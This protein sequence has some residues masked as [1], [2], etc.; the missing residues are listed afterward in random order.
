[1]KNFFKKLFNI[2][3]ISV[4]GDINLGFWSTIAKPIIVLAPMA[5]VTDCAFREVIA[6]Y[7]KPD[8]MWTEFVSADGL[9]CGGFEHLK[10]DLIFS[11]A[12]KPIVAQFFTSN[13]DHME[14][15]ARL[16]SEMGFDG[17]D[18]NMG[19]PD[20]SI[21]RQGCGSA[22]IK[23]PAKAREIIRAAIKGSGGLPVSV[24]T[25][26][27]YN[28]DQL[29]EWL[30]ELLA[31]NPAVVTIHARTRKEM[32][33]VPARWERIKRAVEIRNE[34]KAKTLIFG[35]G[36]ILSPE[37]AF[38]IAK[39]TG[40]DG[41]M[42]GKGIFGKPWLFENLVE[43]KQAFLE[44]RECEVKEK[45]LA[46][47]LRIAVEHTKTFEKHL[48]PVKNFAIMKKHFK[49]YANGFDNAGALR[50]RLFSCNDADEIERVVEH[51]LDTKEILP[52]DEKEI[53]I[54]T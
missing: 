36:D 52:K 24:K 29:E 19:C 6:K 22:M 37:E 2:Q 50:D 23:T 54:S 5:D 31:E 49:A 10:Y 15:A 8:V 21:E 7:G 14:K 30:P 13:P 12:E 20:R 9:F 4:S 39:E 1:V 35:N 17:I 26:L 46:E 16:A 28:S 33:K 48:G 44:G 25:R 18:I 40:A 45:T 34:L 51:F 41:V 3:K 47:K 43:K 32:S 27:G 38:K 11:P 53:G 42:I